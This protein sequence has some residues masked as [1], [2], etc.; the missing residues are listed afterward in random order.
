METNYSKR[1][2]TLAE[3][4]ITLG[5]IGVVASITLPTLISNHK[6]QVY[7]VAIKK[8]YA[9][10]LQV[11]QQA[12]AQDGVDN[13]ILA[14]FCSGGNNVSAGETL[15]KYF[16]IVK[17]CGINDTGC[18]APVNEYRSYNNNNLKRTSQIPG[19]KVILAS[20]VSLSLYCYSSSSG[21]DNAIGSMYI[22]TNGL[23]GPN[24]GGRDFFRAYIYPEGVL[25]GYYVDYNCRR[26]IGA[27]SD[28]ANITEK[29]NYNFNTWCANPNDT[30]GCFDHLLSNG[31]KMDY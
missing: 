31:W 18:F 16:K 23:K 7:A 6:K 1:A 14:N 29:R 24:V 28:F 12:K 26:S 25:D 22:D 4:L 10:M 19:Y 8:T 9:E 11:F 2:F 17:D 3:V 15:K 27:C 13:L 20:G 30:D 5:V 21:M